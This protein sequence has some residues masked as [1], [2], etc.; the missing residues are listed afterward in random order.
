MKTYRI[1]MVIIIGVLPFLAGCPERKSVTTKINID[2]SC[3]R[4]IGEFDLKKFK[5]IDSL[6]HDLPI[7][8]DHSWKL[9]TINDSTA[10]LTKEFENVSD[11]NAL[12]SSDAS[13]L[14]VYQR[15]V[16][17]RKKFRWFHTVFQYY[18]TYGGLLTE[19]PLS[20][21]LTE[22]EI[23]IFKASDP[24]QR[25]EMINFDS[26]A[27][28]SLLDNMEER[29]DYWFHDHLFSMFFDD[30]IT[31]ADSSHLIKITAIDPTELKKV[32]RQ[33][34]D[35]TGD[36]DLF[37]DDSMGIKELTRII[38]EEWGL[39]SAQMNHFQEISVKVN[40]EEKYEKEL[41]V[42]LSEEYDNKVNMPGLLMD[43]NAEIVEGDTLIWGVDLIKYIDSDFVMFA[44][45]KVTNRWAYILSGFI[46]LIAV[47]IPFLGKLKR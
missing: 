22:K 27:R 13:S 41:F 18:E 39:D 38:G 37:S 3:V 12:Y 4:T 20:N 16:E 7:P 17:L 19:I 25:P 47:I 43:T 1:F 24:D 2:G 21:Y 28:K 33:Q 34:V 44:E 30:L 23:E 15:K 40:L 32:V 10:V 14:N 8:I 6:L 45:S 42:G 9:D 36:I 5:G 11:L 26:L 35:K 29:F 46:I 31:I